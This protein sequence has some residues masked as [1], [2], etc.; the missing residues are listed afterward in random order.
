MRW[1][2]SPSHPPETPDK[3]KFRCVE[4]FSYKNS[5]KSQGKF[6]K[7]VP[8]IYNFSP[9]FFGKFWNIFLVL[10][11]ASETSKVWPRIDYIDSLQTRVMY[12]LLVRTEIIEKNRNQI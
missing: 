5:T 8:E 11:V 1:G 4:N 2:L 6:V 7:I 3:G 9:K 10:I 12:R